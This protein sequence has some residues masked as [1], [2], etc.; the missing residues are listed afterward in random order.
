MALWIE[1]HPDEILEL[2]KFDDFRTELGW[3][4]NEALGFLGRFWGKVLKLRESGDVTGWRPDHV[5]K[6]TGVKASPDK[7]WA[8]LGAHWLTQRGDRLLVHDWLE[9]AGT[10]LRGKYKT[11]QKERLVEIWAI[12][13]KT[14]G[15][16]ETSQN[17]HKDA[18]RSRE[19]VG[20]EQ[21]SPPTDRPD[22]PNLPTVAANGGVSGDDGRPDGPPLPRGDSLIEAT[23]MMKPWHF[24][25][26]HHLKK[27]GLLPPD[28]CRWALRNIKKLSPEERLAC[29]II[30]KRS[31][32]LL[33][34]GPT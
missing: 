13:G 34:R 19:G 14:Y 20:K 4:E 27:T 23:L 1:F 9:Y 18:G 6:I 3:S 7:L 22:L 2:Q 24:K 21:G 11:R 30:V 32:K 12:H 25:G 16:G 8:A 10:Y 31:E 15:N 5:A 28:Y 26:E 33:A 17:T 29:E